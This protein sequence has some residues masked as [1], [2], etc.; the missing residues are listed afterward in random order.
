MNKRL[1]IL[2][3]LFV[4]LLM[5]PTA[6]Q[7]QV[8]VEKSTEIIT[9][10]GKQFYMHHV[11]KGQTLY[12]IAKTYQISEAEIENLNPEVKEVGLQANMVLGISV[13][14]EEQTTVNSEEQPTE[15]PAEKPKDAPV[16]FADTIVLPKVSGLPITEDDEIGDAY[17]IHTVKEGEKTKHLLRR[18]GVSEEEFRKL[19]PSVG[20]RVFVGQKVLIPVEIPKK[21]TLVENPSSDTLKIHLQHPQVVDTIKEEEPF[22]E[23]FML[24]EEKPDE[25]YA[26]A[27]NASRT[28][29]VALLV[30]LYL[31][32]IDRLDLSKA[33]IEKTKHSRAMK[34]L[35]FYEGFMMAVDSLT[36]HYGLKLELNVMDVSENVA[37]AQAAVSALEKEQVDLIIGP[38]FSKSFAIVE[39]YALSQNILVVNPMSERESIIVNAPN[40]V[41][42]KP[43]AKAMADELGDLI[44]L[45]YPKARVTLMCNS[46]TKDSTNVAMIEEALLNAVEQEVRLSNA[47]MLELITKESARRKMGKRVLSTLEVEGQIFSTNQLRDNPDGEVYFDNPFHRITYS[48]SDVF[49]RGLSTARD[50]VLV[51][52]GDNVVFA[53]QILNSI[54]RSA[55]KYPITLIGL[56]NWAGFDNLLVPNLLNM[57][58]IYFD[59]HFVDYNSDWA[60]SFVE[61]FQ[62]TY[63]CDPLDYAFEGYDVA[64]YFLTALKEFGPHAQECLPYYHPALLHSRYY[65]TK[66]RAED[67]LENRFWNIYQYDNPSV[68]LKPVFIYS[69][70]N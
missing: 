30:P 43:S 67:G 10:S 8:E 9:I 24:P 12:S 19:N 59:D 50:N 35:H 49:K 64:W 28:Y 25:C 37:G 1:L 70:E 69:E 61:K 46:E 6:V 7:A 3:L 63:Q 11:K 14:S 56:P 16:A 48:E 40:V 42:L 41:K 13:V 34:F 5:L 23:E 44:R 57:N 21:P 32:E 47:E 20:S 58:A 52:Y 15:K 65:F 22:E 54:N 51:A 39:E 17:V 60:Q 2:W 26:S 27:D 62:D 31:N 55:K 4:G 66:K 45:K 53:T 29:H 38:F 36:K 18:W 33:R 68:E